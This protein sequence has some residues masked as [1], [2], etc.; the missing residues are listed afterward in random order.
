MLLLSPISVSQLSSGQLCAFANNSFSIFMWSKS[1]ICTKTSR[2]YDGPTDIY[3]AIYVLTMRY[4][5]NPLFVGHDQEPP[6]CRAQPETPI[7]RAR[8]GTPHLSGTTG[9]PP[10]VWENATIKWQTRW[11]LRL[12]LSCFL[13]RY[14]DMTS[15]ISFSFMRGYLSVCGGGRCGEYC[16]ESCC[17]SLWPEGCIEGVFISKTQ[18]DQIQRN[19]TKFIKIRPNPTEFDQVWPNPTKSNRIYQ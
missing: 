8:P 13:T 18:S 14:N 16:G 4:D 12:T 19:P 6:I 9:N 11:P 15:I 10:F 1:W 5:R 2:R 7:C 17:G 3:H